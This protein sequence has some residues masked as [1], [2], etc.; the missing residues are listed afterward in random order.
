MPYPGRAAVASKGNPT[1]VLQDVPNWRLRFPAVRS[2]R[3][4]IEGR[5]SGA[6]YST[7]SNTSS[8]AVSRTRS[9]E[10][11]RAHRRASRCG[12][13]VHR[14]L[15]KPARQPIGCGRRLS[16]CNPPH[17]KSEVL[18][19]DSIHAGDHPGASSLALRRVADP[20]LNQARSFVISSAPP[21]H[22][23]IREFGT[24]LPACGNSF[25]WLSQSTDKT[26]RM[27]RDEAE[28]VNGLRRE[29]LRQEI[30]DL[31][32]KQAAALR[33]SRRGGMSLRQS[34]DYE[35]RRTLITMLEVRLQRLTFI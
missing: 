10:D 18:A 25:T 27:K 22:T 14:R 4:L 31:R 28:I 5:N 13:R 30:A 23:T 9:P 11:H 12:G 2:L 7:H 17:G 16:G 6:T 15:S 1:K 32:E 24:Y 20:P 19:F 26:L 8:S 21:V 33:S 3:S 35:E 34:R 29:R